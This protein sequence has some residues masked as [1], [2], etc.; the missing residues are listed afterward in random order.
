MNIFPI[1]KKRPR[2]LHRKR[3]IMASDIKNEIR[4]EK[5]LFESLL[6][7]AKEYSDTS[8]ELVKLKIIDRIV[9]AISSVIPVV[10]SV[11]LFSSCLLFASL[12]LAFWLAEL[13]GK[14]FYGF[15][16][17]AGIY[18]LLAVIIQFILH[19]SIK[20]MLGDIFVRQLLK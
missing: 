17:V 7:S 15:F 4:D 9:D 14:V 20:K 3:S 10:I 2:L 1:L 12:G 16:I 13:T 11:I 18:V 8:I 19:R 6:E 5:A